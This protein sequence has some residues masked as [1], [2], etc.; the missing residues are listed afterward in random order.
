[1]FLLTESLSPASGPEEKPSD[2]VIGLKK[3]K[4]NFNMTWKHK[5]Q[6]S[7]WTSHIP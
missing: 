5:P 3:K 1:M 7:L 2:C 4:L 6:V